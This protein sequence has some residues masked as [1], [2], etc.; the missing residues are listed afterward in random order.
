[1]SINCRLGAERRKGGGHGLCPGP[2]FN[3]TEVVRLIQHEMGRGGSR[4]QYLSVPAKE[5]LPVRKA[6]WRRGL[7]LSPECWC[8]FGEEGEERAV[9][10]VVWQE[11]RVSH[12]LVWEKVRWGRLPRWPVY[13]CSLQDVIWPKCLENEAST[14]K[15]A[16][17]KISG[18]HFNFQN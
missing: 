18:A 8:E 11:H 14:T 2:P 10:E 4:G 17:T 6:P 7:E 9:H 12:P 1:M 16:L 13:A 5:D 3:L 15:T